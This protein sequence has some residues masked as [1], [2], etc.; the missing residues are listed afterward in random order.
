MAGKAVTVAVERNP[1]EDGE[2]EYY[3]GS[4]PLASR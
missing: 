4:A 3:G 1:E 2:I